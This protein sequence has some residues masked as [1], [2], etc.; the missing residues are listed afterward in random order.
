M[1]VLLLALIISIALIAAAC[2]SAPGPQTAAPPQPTS[3]PAAAPAAT[4]SAGPKRGGKVTLGLW[5]SPVTLNYYL[6]TQ[7]VVNEVNNFVTEGLSHVLPDS[8]REPN[9]AKEIP[10]IQNGGVSADGKTVTWKLKEGMV[11]SDGS[12]LACEDVKHTWQAIMTPGVGVVT[13]VGYSEIENVECPN[14]QTVILKFKNFYAPYLSL[15]DRAILPRSAGDPKDMKNWAYN[16]K[17][18]GTGP[19][20][21][22]EWVAD[23]H[24]S[25][26]RN[27]NYREKNK[28]YLDQVIIR[29]VPS[30]DVLLQL[31]IS[32]EVDIMWANFEGD[33]PLLE[34]NPNIVISSRPF[35]GGERIVLNTAENKDPSDPTKPHAIL[36]D[37]RVR[38]AIMYGLNKQTVIDKL[39]FGKAKPGTSEMNEGYFACD[40]IKGYPYD[41]EKAKKLLDEAGWVPGPDGIRIAKSAKYAPDGTRLRL[42]FATTSGNKL[43]EDSQVIWSENMKAIGVEFFIENGPSSVVLGTWD[44]GAPY[45]HGNFDLM[46]YTTNAS[47]DPHA[48]MVNLFASWTIVSEK[49]K[50]GTNVSRFNDPKVD[51]LL[52]QAGAEIDN[53]KRKALYCQTAQIINDSASTLYVYQRNRIH[54]YRDRIQGPVAGN[55]W[56]NVGW[57]SQDWWI[58]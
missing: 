10:T 47:A 51:E 15:F 21:V 1:R 57:A 33:Y 45:R 5:Q 55:A 4:P 35:I 19:F 31:L 8:T 38:Q 27:P 48:Q 9:L 53:A 12:P 28:P 39:L 3:A 2:A 6:G 26:S 7:T 58:K 41:P 56:E 49:N 43:R 30:S 22:D 40:N 18:V 29:L 36:G 13:T 54:S 42:K 44:S 25:L 23:D 37:V 46:M 50:S 52:K 24:V 14:P 32:G 34:K 11:F 20:K 16:R 17:P